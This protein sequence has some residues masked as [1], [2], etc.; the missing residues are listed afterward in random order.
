MT[1]I[2]GSGV[3]PDA[4]FSGKALLSGNR[5]FTEKGGK[6]QGSVRVSVTDDAS[7]KKDMDIKFV[8]PEGFKKPIPEKLITGSNAKIEGTLVKETKIHFDIC[9]GCGSLISH[10]HESVYIIASEITATGQPDPACINHVEGDFLIT[11]EKVLL[12][13]IN[14]KSEYAW[15]AKS[16]QGM[17]PDL[18]G[19]PHGMQ[20]DFW[21][22]QWTEDRESGDPV[23]I[24]LG[25][26]IHI[27][28]FLQFYQTAPTCY[29]RFCGRKNRHHMS[30]T[31]II[32][33]EVKKIC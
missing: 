10:I 33:L 26:L 24:Y 21:I 11:S 30:S 27:K 32:P 2:S 18:F 14:G 4:V 13:R 5:S 29:C 28:G 8:I 1:Y 20:G 16:V 23:R 25:D 19:K 31:D 9:P 12:S 3:W 22:R 6:L 17:S 7:V 15:Q